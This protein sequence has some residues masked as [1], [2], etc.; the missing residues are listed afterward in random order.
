M[1]DEIEKFRSEKYCIVKIF[2][3]EL[4]KTVYPAVPSLWVNDESECFFPSDLKIDRKV[5][6]AIEKCQPSL[7]GWHLF[8]AKILTS[9]GIVNLTQ[10][11]HV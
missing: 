4:D 7:P 8:P 2:S 1:A 6:K 11:Y 5:K 3:A 10:P 9:S